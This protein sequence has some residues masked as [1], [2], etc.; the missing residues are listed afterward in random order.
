M[1][2]L[3]GASRL[4]GDSDSETAAVSAQAAEKADNHT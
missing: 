2:T 1:F 3:F 4:S